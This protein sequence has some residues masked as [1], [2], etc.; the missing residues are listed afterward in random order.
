MTTKDQLHATLQRQR[1]ALL[2]KLDGLDE[3]ELR[4]PRTPTG[5]N[6]LGVL[7]HVA[8]VEA[9]YLGAVFDR[10]F[11]EPMPWLS[12]QAPDNADLWCTAEQTPEWTRAFA[13][14]AWA[15]CEATVTA[16]DLDSPGVVP[17]W[18]AER[19][20]VTLGG[21]LGHLIGEVGRHLGQVDILREQ[22][23][24]STGY[25]AV[26]PNLPDHDPDWW[27][28]QYRQLVRLADESAR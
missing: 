13:Q 28:D 12:A 24:D 11:L 18:P 3:R 10:P 5:T 4:L 20:E 9:G 8:S 7:K 17:W 14:R 25:L 23:D 1:A 26:H 16:L 27:T 15:H 2:W 19:R 6:L 21:I 22:L